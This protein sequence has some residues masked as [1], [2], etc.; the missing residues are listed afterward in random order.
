MN[1]SYKYYKFQ[2]KT[3]KRKM[4]HPTLSGSCI[5]CK[6]KQTAEKNKRFCI[7]C[8]KKLNPNAHLTNAKRC[9]LCSNKINSEKFKGINNPNFKHGESCENKKHYYYIQWE[10]NENQRKVREGIIATLPVPAR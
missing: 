6:K 4:S 3:C 1:K 7:D 10:T 5:E 2:C 9:H 8:G